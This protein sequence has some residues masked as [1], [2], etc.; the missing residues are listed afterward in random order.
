MTTMY[1]YGW[2]P[3][4]KDPINDI[5]YKLSGN[6]LPPMMDLRPKMPAVYDQGQL[7]CHDDK[8]E[9][10]TNKGWML[11]SKVSNEEELATV[12]PIDG[13]LYF[14]K[15]EKLFSF[16]YDGEMYLCDGRKKN[17]CVTPN[18]KM[19]IRKWNEGERTLSN[20]YT[21]VEIDKIGW[22]SGLLVSTVTIN[23]N[24]QTITIKGVDHKRK[25]YRED[26]HVDANDYLR[27]LGIYLSDGTMCPSFHHYKIQIAGVD[28]RKDQYRKELFARLGINTC[29]LKDRY[30]FEDKRIFLM[31]KSYGLLGVKAPQKYVPDFVFSLGKENIEAFLEGF[32]N[33]DGCEQ[34]GLK[35]YYTSSVQLANDLQ[36]LLILSGSWGTLTKREPRESIIR[37]RLIFGKN[38][39]HRVSQWKSP[40]LSID[41]NEDLEVVNYSGMVYCAEINP[42]HTL[43]TRR[44]GKVLI[45]GNSC[46]ANGIAGA[47]EYN[48]KIMNH[49]DFMPSRL[50]IYYN[51]REK[52][53][54]NL[55]CWFQTF[56]PTYQ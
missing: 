52:V 43:I 28:G 19:I 25:S 50:F 53:Q 12:N 32:F 39:E 23:K 5:P 36:R 49:P 1:K 37:G 38:P 15:P 45:S 40:N 48:F 42:Y 30:T 54:T 20:D 2:R 55:L 47:I 17:F 56:Y 22:Y 51:E 10:L 14:E 46:T 33:G 41:K 26:T 24:I 18:H 7:G 3:D 13:K 16:F 4:I 29:N 6:K 8:T 35:N 31:L 34:D 11:F 9:V 44:E 27:L 21:F